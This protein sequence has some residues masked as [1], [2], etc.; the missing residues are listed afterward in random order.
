MGDPFAAQGSLG[1]EQT[2]QGMLARQPIDYV[3]L[4]LE[5]NEATVIELAGTARRRVDHQIDIGGN[6]RAVVSGG[7]AGFV[8]FDSWERLEAHVAEAVALAQMAAA[9]SFAPR[10][11]WAPSQV[12]QLRARV[13]YEEDPRRVST[14]DKVALLQEYGEFGLAADPAI[15]GVQTRYFDRYRHLWFF[16]SLGSLVEQEKM[17]LG[18]S[19]LL[20]ARRGGAVAQRGVSF[21]SSNDFGAVRGLDGAIRDAARRAVALLD[22][23]QIAGG[24]YTVVIDPHLAGV[25]AHEAFGHLSE[26]DGQVDDAGVLAAMQLGRRFGPS[27]LH[28]YDTG[29]DAGSR[30]YLPV[31]DEGVEARDVDLI[32]GGELVGRLHSRRTAGTLHEAPTGNARALHYR[33]APIV[34]MRNTVIAPGD[35]PFEG[36]FQGIRRGIYAAGSTGGQTNGELFAFRA[37]EAYLIEDGRIT[38]P[39][40]NAVLTG[41][42]FATLSHITAIGSDFTRY[43][44]G[45]GCGKAGQMPLPVSHHAPSLRIERCLVGGVK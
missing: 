9:E 43:E 4:R 44:G 20:I 30:G 38:Q 27:N 21:G 31:D 19:V 3:E 41:N 7:Y 42:V 40:R 25:F 13:P 28:I 18:G 36:L 24:E 45:G 33:F 29:H 15:K 16:N 17:D 39:L 26:A 23:P 12:I 11:A 35:T 5:V 37:A 1:L 34:R 32:K 14:E 10:D 22:A 2:I 6:V 8:H